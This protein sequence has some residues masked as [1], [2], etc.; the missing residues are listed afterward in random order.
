[1]TFEIYQR[2]TNDYFEK[3]GY[4]EWKTIRDE[5]NPPKAQEQAKTA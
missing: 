3:N 5:M 4:P 1:V 2:L